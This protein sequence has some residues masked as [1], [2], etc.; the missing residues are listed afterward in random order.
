MYNR[1]YSFL[2]K[3]IFFYNYQFGFRKNHFTSHA[4][5]ILVEKIFQSFACKK[6]T[7]EIF[8]DL[9]KAFY[10]ID[11]TILLSKLNHYGVRG[12]AL[13][14]RLLLG[15]YEARLKLNFA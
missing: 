5:S 1:L 6:A 3:Q 11:H 2:E 8:L 10:A 7:L 12:N 15:A 4:I 13:T 9:S 14:L